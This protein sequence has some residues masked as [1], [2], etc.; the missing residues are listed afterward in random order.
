M[1]KILLTVMMVSSLLAFNA[2]TKDGA[3]G[4]AGP[5]GDA[6]APGAAGAKGEV[7]PAGAKGADGA[8]IRTGDAA[9]AAS[10]GNDGDFYFDKTAKVLYG[11]KAAGAWPATGT[12]LTG[13][14]GKDGSSVLF[15]A[16][17]PTEADGKVG[18]FY[19][20]TDKS[21]FYGPKAEDG[22][23]AT[24]NQ[25]PLGTGGAKVYYYNVG[26]SDVKEVA[27]TKV[28]GQD[29]VATYPDYRIFSTYKV[30]ADDIIRIAQ[31]PGWGDN[32]VMLFEAN[33]GDGN[34]NVEPADATA[35]G[36]IP[37]GTRFIF[38]ADDSKVPA[39]F[40]LS[41]AD[42]DRLTLNPANFDYLLNAK[43]DPA[44][45]ALGKDLNFA[46]V[47]NIGLTA[48][49]T[50]YTVNYTAKVAFDLDKII[51]NLEKNIQDGG[52]ILLRTKSYNLT[53]G[54]LDANW[55]V[56]TLANFRGTYTI[57]GVEYGPGLKTTKV[58][59]ATNVNILGLGASLGQIGDATKVGTQVVTW[60]KTTSKQGDFSY[61]YNIASGDAGTGTLNVNPAGTSYYSTVGDHLTASTGVTLTAAGD[62]TLKT[63]DKGQAPSFF[64]GQKLR[65]IS[66]TVL[67]AETVAAAKKAGINLDDANALE[68]FISKR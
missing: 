32:R 61:E 65:L 8:T 48:S 9:P 11:P 57:G 33:P 6:G 31:Y 5:K 22:S 34:F 15:G 19:F 67:N 25:L 41:Q 36:N 28:F 43:A 29:I 54:A 38:K 42:K 14:A 50:K 59:A 55:D 16:G 20:S 49:T 37:A 4:P 51:P 68:Q 12:S 63:N 62:L 2:C 17:V 13:P 10:L 35:L 40:N 52:L 53:T 64:T 58:D 18:D 27:N 7:G 60:T 26:F 44:T 1:R 3:Q 24:G 21:T 66:A 46:N 23:W 39:I 47:K 45:I 56:T 30:N